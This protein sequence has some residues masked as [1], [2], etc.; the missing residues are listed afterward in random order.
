MFYHLVKLANGNNAGITTINELVNQNVYARVTN[1]YSDNETLYADIEF[2]GTGKIAG[3]TVN[4]IEVLSTSTKINQNLY[5]LQGYSSIKFEIDTVENPEG[6]DNYI[7][8]NFVLDAASNN[9]TINKN[10]LDTVTFFDIDS[11][12]VV[13]NW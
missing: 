11:S 4:K 1:Y 8:E 2:V 13:I 3:S 5:V 10:Y 9:L 7:N 12:Q 6:S